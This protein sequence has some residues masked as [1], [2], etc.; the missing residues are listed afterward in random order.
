[1]LHTLT[2]DNYRGFQRYQLRNLGRVNLLVGPHNCGK[3]SVLEAVQILVSRGDPRVLIESARRR[4]ETTV[5]EDRHMTTRYPLHHHFHGHKL[6]PG[7]GFVVSSDDGLHRVRVHI[8]EADLG[9]TV[10]LF[11]ILSKTDRPL[12][13]VIRSEYEDDV[14][15]LP[16]T[17]DG[18][19]DQSPSAIRHLANLPPKRPPV[20][21]F[22]A[23][24]LQT[25]E[26]TTSWNRVVRQGQESEVV[27]SMKILQE[28]LK[29]I[30]FLAGDSGG[31]AWGSGGILLGFQNGAPRVPIGSYG[32][33]M[34][35][36]LAL[37]LSL[38]SAAQG[39]LLVDEIDTGLHWSIME[40]M[41]TLVVEAALTSSI[42]VFS[43]THSLD[44]INGLAALLRKRPDLADAVSIQKVERRLD[45]SVSLGAAD[46]VTANDLSIELR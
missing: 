21:F 29:S 7:V 27:E 37:S 8:V 4:W 19:L 41:W 39:F 33:G 9:E 44:C 26:M 20:Q 12:A 3:T 46:I 40:D 42:Q 5:S 2:L 11:D 36:L 43:T 24:S 14:K 22:T 6:E 16:L 1:M 35:R 38:V 18:C 13:L 15:E 17:E 25:R 31:G 10:D 45:R 28:D 34:R 32:D 30:H 23:E